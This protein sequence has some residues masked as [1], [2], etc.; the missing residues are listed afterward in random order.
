MSKKVFISYRRSD[1]RADAARIRDRLTSLL[2]EQNVFMDV[3]NLMAGQRFDIALERELAKCDVLL[4][5]I[6]TRWLDLLKEKEALG[7]DDFVR[8]EIAAAL[9]RGIPVIPVMVDGAQ[10][11]KKDLL[12][13]DLRNLALYQKLD[14]SHEHFS[15]DVE[16]LLKAI[17]PAL[18]VERPKAASP[19][20]LVLAAAAAAAVAAAAYV[21]LALRVPSGPG[22]ATENASPASLSPQSEAAGSGQK[23]GNAAEIDTRTAVKSGDEGGS[24]KGLGHSAPE[25]AQEAKTADEA[26]RP[27]RQ[28]R[29]CP[30][31]CPEMV[32]I[33]P[34]EFTMGTTD[35]DSDER[36]ARKVS[37]GKAFAAGRFEVTFAEWDACVEE[38]GCKHKPA[39]DWGRERQ[40]VMRVSWDD[41]ARDYLPWLSRKTGAS[42]RLMTE[43]EWEYVA[44]AGNSLRFPTGETASPKSAQLS[45]RRTAE[46]GT[47]PANPWSLHDL[48]GSVWEWVQD[49]HMSSFSGAPPDG[50]AARETSGCVRVLRGGSWNTGAQEAR[51][52]N[53]EWA[54]PDTRNNDIGFRVA[55]S[56]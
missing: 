15:R 39:A 44:K 49:C 6:G 10:M 53:R 19:S 54:S 7:E 9:K 33:G 42:Y 17:D 29:D 46:V 27:G 45:Q 41:I 56:M 3:E 16:A 40:P 11:P 26:H 28:F 38:G 18:G 50:T 14:V 37:I 4:A 13:E 47:F 48:A 55:R 36:P 51:S 34:G 32:V 35:G 8:D 5:V 1:A 24:E 43:A 30:D 23:T 25:A 31:V 22:E 20:R 21:G 2:G 52:T 12:P